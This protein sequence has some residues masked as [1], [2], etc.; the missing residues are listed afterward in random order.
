[1]TDQAPNSKFLSFASLRRV[2]Q[3]SRIITSS[4]EFVIHHLF[5]GI[6]G[7]LT[8]KMSGV[9]FQWHLCCAL[10]NKTRDPGH[11]LVSSRIPG[12]SGYLF[13]V[14]LSRVVI[15]LVLVLACLYSI[16]YPLPETVVM[17]L[18]CPSMLIFLRSD[19]IWDSIVFENGSAFISHT[20]SIIVP[21]D[22]TLPRCF[23]R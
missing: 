3:I 7:V 13:L 12:M 15:C 17:S 1:M 4:P 5:P 19:K 16:L 23:M 18:R 6:F 22:N 20:C 9:S 14:S 2:I 10:I 21:R 8:E 11:T